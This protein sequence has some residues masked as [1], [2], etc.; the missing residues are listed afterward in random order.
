[1]TLQTV[2]TA[3]PTYLNAG[4]KHRGE[5]ASCYLFTM[6]DT[7]NSISTIPFPTFLTPFNVAPRPLNRVKLTAT[8]P[9]ILLACDT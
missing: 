2:Q 8:P 3:T 6:D 5:L 4:R 1:M 9:A 7:L